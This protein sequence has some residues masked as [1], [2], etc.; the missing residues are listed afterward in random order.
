MGLS[1]KVQREFLSQSVK[2]TLGLFTDYF[3]FLLCD[4]LLVSLLCRHI[5]SKLKTLIH[6]ASNRDLTL[7][8]LVQ[9][10]PGLLCF[11]QCVPDIEE[12]EFQ[13]VP[14]FN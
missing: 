14:E 11:L 9:L 1:D 2:M 10:K 5:F 6:F 13:Q 12:K 8:F 3:I 4:I 7:E